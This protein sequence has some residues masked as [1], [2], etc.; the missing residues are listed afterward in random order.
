MNITG[1]CGVS[2]GS[3]PM[4][5]SF[6][7]RHREQSYEISIASIHRRDAVTYSQRSATSGSIFVAR[8]AGIQQPSVADKTNTTVA[9][10]SVIGSEGE[11]CTNCD[12]NTRLT[13]TD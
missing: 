4:A 6:A 1:L 9:T 3:L 7:H 5:F 10:I 12:S 13:T 2:P 11:T 8:R